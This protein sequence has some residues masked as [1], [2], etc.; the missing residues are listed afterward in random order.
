MLLA[1]VVFAAHVRCHSP[2][3]RLHCLSAASRTHV[4]SHPAFSSC[5]HFRETS[6]IYPV[7]RQKSPFFLVHSSAVTLPA[8][9]LPSLS[10]ACRLHMG[11]HPAFS[12][13]KPMR[14]S[15]GNDGHF[16]TFLAKVVFF[17]AAHVGSHSSCR[18][19]VLAHDGQ[20][21]AHT[22]HPAFSSCAHF[23]E[24]LRNYHVPRQKSSF[25]LHHTPAVTLPA[26][27]LHW[28]SAAYRLHMALH[29]RL[30]FLQAHEKI[31]RKQWAFH[32]FPGKSRLYPC[33]TRLQS[34][35]L[36]DDCIGSRRPTRLHMPLHPAFHSFQLMRI[37]PGHIGI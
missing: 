8:A 23:P 36:P 32:K 11:L 19:T 15:P 28:L 37:F 26:A 10:A 34:L 14:I 25:S 29:P 20:P 16:I 22:L 6:G 31:S 5:A 2:A 3:G 21:R 7:P 30:L 27:R 18:A 12:S 1:K 13:F 35:F 24:T 9:G 17:L 33:S 4:S